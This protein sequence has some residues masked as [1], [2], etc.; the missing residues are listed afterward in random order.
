MGQEQSPRFVYEVHVRLSPTTESRIVL[1]AS[2]NGTCFAELV[3]GMEGLVQSIVSR[4]TRGERSSVHD[5]LEHEGRAALCEAVVT[6]EEGK[7]R[8]ATFAGR[9]ILRSVIGYL[10]TIDGGTQWRARRQ[11]EARHLRRMVTDELDDTPEA[12]EQAHVATAWGRKMSYAVP[13]AGEEQLS[14]VPLEDAPESFL[15]RPP[16]AEDGA[17]GRYYQ[18]WQALTR[19]QRVLVDRAE[20]MGMDAGGVSLSQLAVSVGQSR[21]HVQARLGE[22]LAVLVVGDS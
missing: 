22:A 7:G 18:R 9:R 16:E 15:G 4:A 8:F 14:R 19:A 1:H 10:R 6:W 2:G 20:R 21:S 17:E 3:E 11:Q 13:I 5:E 12:W